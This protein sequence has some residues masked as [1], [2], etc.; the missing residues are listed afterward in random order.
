[1]NILEQLKSCTDLN[2]LATLLGYSPKVFSYILFSKSINYQY[3]KFEIDKKDGSKRIIHAP[4]EKLKE[5]QRSLANVL[6]E[7]YNIIEKNRL[8]LTNKYQCVL[9]HGFR[10]KLVLDL[11]IS[12]KTNI[13]L[14]S[15]EFIFGITSN[16]K[17][18]INKKYILNIDLKNFFHSI[19]FGRIVGFFEKNINFNLTKKVAILIAQIATYRDSTNMV[20]FLPQGSPCS[21]IISNLISGILDKRLYE[22]AKENKCTYTRFAD[23]ITFSTNI[24][25]FPTNLAILS[26]EKYTPSNQL[27]RII[28]KTGFLI[29]PTKTRL[30]TFEDRQVVTGLVVNKKVNVSSNY[31][32]YTKSMINKYCQEGI[33]YKSKL[34]TNEKITTSNSLQG[35]L[36]F[37][38]NIK[39]PAFVNPTNYKEFSKLDSI[40]KLSLKLNFHKNFIHNTET[41]II[42]EGVSD[43]MHFKNAYKSLY[44]SNKYPFF[45]KVLTSFNS[46]VKITGIGNGTGNL[47]HFLSMYKKINTS[48]INNIN[49]CI[50]LVDGDNEGEKVLTAAKKI[51]DKNCY[52]EL[53]FFSP[54]YN[55]DDF[56]VLHCEKNLYIV[57]LPTNFTIED[58]YDPIYKTFT[59]GT[60]TLKLSNEDLDHTKFYGKTEFFEYVIKPNS[61]VIDF[62]NF[63]KIFEVLFHV[64][65]Y[66]FFHSN[67]P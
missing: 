29:N 18:H 31:Y 60:R 33:Y 57:M 1:M 22:F 52:K 20:G 21:P 19:T 39:K 2:S 17:A 49:P 64:Q 62:T 7:C 66:N 41:R 61:H 30:N 48:K 34:H 36:D 4:K 44:K 10:N 67:L 46:L 5:L 47:K 26:N 14:K 63:K 12:N 42:C 38:F 23:D 8:N 43:P 32:R 16:A 6:N 58:L 50:V 13:K 15:K 56:Q 3:E 28:E 51:F 40:E 27:I 11:P 45:F 65:L 55:L 25:N 37:I 24:K 54:F 35:I 53:S 59:L 9:S